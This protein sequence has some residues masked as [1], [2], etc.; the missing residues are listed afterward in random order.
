APAPAGVPRGNASGCAAGT[1][2]TARGSMSV[3][4][5]AAEVER[6]AP[7]LVLAAPGGLGGALA[8]ARYRLAGLAGRAGAQRIGIDRG[9]AVA[10][11]DAGAGAGW[12]DNAK[13]DRRSRG[14]SLVR[15]RT[16]TVPQPGRCGSRR[17]PRPAREAPASA[18]RPGGGGNMILPQMRM[19]PGDGHR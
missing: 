8:I 6:F 2:Y 10:R 11:F 13:R 18:R 3:V 16:E 14:V 17:A 5:P 4:L 7:V 15:G 1:R 12:G 9:V 19:A